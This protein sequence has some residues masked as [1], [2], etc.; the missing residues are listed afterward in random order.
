MIDRMLS[1][2]DFVSL[3]GAGHKNLLEYYS[4]AN[5]INVF[6]VADGDTGNNIK[7]SLEGVVKELSSTQFSGIHH[8]LDFAVELFPKYA[9][10]NSGKILSLFFQNLF[11]N[12]QDGTGTIDITSFVSAGNYAINKTWSILEDTG[13]VPIEGTILSTIRTAFERASSIEDTTQAFGAL[14]DGAIEGLERTPSQ[15]E[16]LQRNGVVDSGALCF[17]YLVEG[18]INHLNGETQHYDKYDHSKISR[19][20]INEDLSVDYC[21]EF[22]ISGDVAIDEFSVL[23]N[24][25]GESGIILPIK[26]QDYSCHVH[27]REDKI[28]EL[29]AYLTSKELKLTDFKLDDLRISPENTVTQTESTSSINGE[30]PAV[31]T[32]TR[33]SIPRNLGDLPNVHQVEGYIQIGETMYRNSEVTLEMMMQSVSTGEKITTAHPSLNDFR[34]LYQQLLGEGHDSILVVTQSAMDSGAYNTAKVAAA[35]LQLGKRITVI[36]NKSSNPATALFIKELS[37]RLTGEY[38]LE[39]AINFVNTS[40]GHTNGFAVGDTTALVTAGYLSEGQAKLTTTTTLP[41]FTHR[42]GKTEVCALVHSAEEAYNHILNSIESDLSKGDYKLNLI[43]GSAPETEHTEELLK[44]VKERFEGYITE[45]YYLTLPPTMIASLGSS[46]FG[47]SYMVQEK[48][49]EKREGLRTASYGD[50]QEIYDLFMSMS[51]DFHPPL[52]ERGDD[53]ET[54]LDKALGEGRM[55]IY[56][57]DGKIV[58]SIFLWH[59]DE[60]KET[61]HVSYAGVSKECRD[62]GIINILHEYLLSQTDC[63]YVETNTWLTNEKMM[64]ILPRLGYKEV[65]REESTFGSDRITVVYETTMN[66]LRGTWETLKGK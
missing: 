23:L 60:S 36:D 37:E 1:H 16:L 12:V 50:R 28:E 22:K 32:C 15:M 4:V 8:F 54:D 25:V 14:Y 43:F 39:N 56:E 51:D 59:T 47:L 2:T 52:T 55:G 62:L 40:I 34:Q 57:I 64:G 53:F 21:L 30:N 9:R 6:P 26:N 5:E 58:G 3:L 61:I 27:L 42:D 35:G 31:I 63:E 66:K 44:R 29:L 17:V 10:G 18:M 49:D 19:T 33:F 65:R 45:L 46:A 7:N 41:I 11:G 38:D 20:R 48:T 24:K 13:F